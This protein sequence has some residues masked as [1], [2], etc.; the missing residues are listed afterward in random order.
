MTGLQPQRTATASKQKWPS[1]LTEQ[2]QSLRTIL[3]S[4]EAPATA[5]TIASIYGRRTAK[6]VQQIGEL[7]ETLVMLGHVQKV[8][9]GGGYTAV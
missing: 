6:R 2:V 3:A 1:S 4:F 9:D 7:L 8:E 5:E